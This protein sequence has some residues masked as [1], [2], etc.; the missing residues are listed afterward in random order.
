[1]EHYNYKG[2]EIVGVDQGFGNMKCRHVIFRSGVRAYDNE[3][4]IVKSEI[5]CK[6]L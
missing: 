4:P 2:K 1:M 5:V 6:L 3:P